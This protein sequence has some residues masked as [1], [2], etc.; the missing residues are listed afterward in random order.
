[1]QRIMDAGQHFAFHVYVHILKFE[2]M[3]ANGK[4]A[5]CNAL[6]NKTMNLMSIVIYGGNTN[7]THSD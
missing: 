3:H 7:A 5:E 1:M 4:W 6:K 2:I